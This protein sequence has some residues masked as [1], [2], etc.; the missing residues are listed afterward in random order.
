MNRRSVPVIIGV[1]Q[2]VVSELKVII[3]RSIKQ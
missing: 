1:G 2:E 3:R